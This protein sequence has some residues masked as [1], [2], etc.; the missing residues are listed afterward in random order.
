MLCTNTW[1]RSDLMTA[2]TEALYGHCKLVYRIKSWSCVPISYNSFLILTIVCS[3]RLH[4]DIQGR[5]LEH[6]EVLLKIHLFYRVC[7]EKLYILKCFVQVTEIT[8]QLSLP[9]QDRAWTEWRTVTLCSRHVSVDSSTTTSCAARP[10]PRSS[11]LR[12]HYLTRE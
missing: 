6:S 8:N 7:P 11:D 9:V 5:D 10:V 4:E 3:L 12:H 2:V 1:G